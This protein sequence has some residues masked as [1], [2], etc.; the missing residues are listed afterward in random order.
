MLGLTPR[1]LFTVLLVVIIIVSFMRSSSFSLQ[2]QQKYIIT[3]TRTIIHR[4]E[5]LFSANTRAKLSL[6]CSDKNAEDDD[7]RIPLE[8]VDNDKPMVYKSQ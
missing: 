3:P 7:R 2:Y 5:Q 8:Y 1:A 6:K 4:N